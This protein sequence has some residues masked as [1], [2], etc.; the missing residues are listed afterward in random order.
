M[1]GFN[2]P[3]PP[4]ILPCLQYNSASVRVQ[5]ESTKSTRGQPSRVG[6]GLRGVYGRQPL[7]G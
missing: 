2:R 3:G 5:Y 6:L 7:F 1:G 4:P